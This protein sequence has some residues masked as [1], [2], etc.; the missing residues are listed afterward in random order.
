MNWAIE[1]GIGGVCE[2][3]LCETPYWIM[4]GWA[5]KG[6]GPIHYFKFED[7]NN[8][9]CF[10]TFFT[11]LHSLADSEFNPFISVFEGGRK[12]PIMSESFT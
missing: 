7:N 11:Q 8:S 6:L 10:L 5:R 3:R 4:Q 12:Q 9:F 2:P 1:D